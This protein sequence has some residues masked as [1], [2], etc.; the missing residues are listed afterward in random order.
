MVKANA[1]WTC[2]MYL[3]KPLTTWVWIYLFVYLLW[4]I[5]FVKCLIQIKNGFPYRDL[6]LANAL[7]FR[8]CS[9][10]NCYWNRRSGKRLY[11][12]TSSELTITYELSNSAVF[13][14]EPPGKQICKMNSISL[15]SIANAD[16]H[17][18][19]NTN[20]KVWYLT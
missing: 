13:N 10:N 16:V 11:S 12:L 15:G 3:P 8:T 5:N 9:E 4:N 2:I 14:W 1:R 19:K 17:K 18:T 7:I 6:H 20:E